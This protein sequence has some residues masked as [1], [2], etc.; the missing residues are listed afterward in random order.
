MAKHDKE[1]AY[2]ADIPSDEYYRAKIKQLESEL[3]F[4]NETVS[5]LRDENAK[6]GRWVNSMD[7]NAQD[8]IAEKDD[9]IAELEEKIVK[10]VTAYV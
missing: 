5:K 8:I 10:L 1:N 2:K 9:R 3:A 7:A 4:A 6:Y